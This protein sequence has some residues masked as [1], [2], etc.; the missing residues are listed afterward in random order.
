[1]ISTFRCV[2]CDMVTAG[3]DLCPACLEDLP[4]MSVC[5][6]YCGLPMLPPQ[7]PLVGL[8]AEG[9]EPGSLPAGCAG[10]SRKA[11]KFDHCL[12]ALLY[13]YP[14]DQ[15]IMA[16]KFRRRRSLSRV[17]GEL[18]AITAAEAF[19]STQAVPDFLLPVPL[20]RLRLITRGYNQAAEIAICLGNDLGL[21]V[22][23][24]VV[25]RVLPTAAQ[26]GLTRTQRFKNLRSA[27]RVNSSLTGKRIAIVDDVFTT[28][29]TVG[30]LTA[31]LRRA[32][33]AE[34]YVW[35][36]ARTVIGR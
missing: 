5:C 7:L 10:C 35:T 19:R 17:L 18:L 14:V 11:H 23:E 12:S 4:W 8:E 20:H 27:F 26:S 13:A 25:T 16:L 9:P 21:P 33:A 30:E 36:V 24:D 3:M 32:G 28:G 29:A 22:R 2:L 31:M 34:V 1:M 15:L 6:R